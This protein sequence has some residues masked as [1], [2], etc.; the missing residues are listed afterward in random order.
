LKSDSKTHQNDMKNVA[1]FK[2]GTA[3]YAIEVIKTER[4]KLAQETA[5]VRW[6]ISYVVN[7]TLKNVTIFVILVCRKSMR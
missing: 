7:I 6:T 2:M 5:G 4:S 3:I 1:M